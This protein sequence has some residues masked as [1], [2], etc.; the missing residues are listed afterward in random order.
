MTQVAGAHEVAGPGQ[1]GQVLDAGPAELAGEIPVGERIRR[2]RQER[3]MSQSELAAGRLSKGFI[4]QIESGRSRP[5]PESLRFIAQRL[6]VP[7]VALLPGL[8]LAQQQA[9]L[10]RAAEAAVKAREQSEA[11]T[12]LD[13]ARP[14]LSTPAELSWYHR[15]RGELL[16]L[17]DELEPA[18]DEALLAFEHV[19]GME[20]GDE[21]VRACNLVGRIHHLAGRHPAALLYLDRAAALATHPSVSPAVRA[22]VHSNRGN[23]HMRLGDPDH[24]LTAYENARAAAQDAEDLWQLAV[25]E[26][27]LGEAA[28]QRGDLPAAIGH[29]ERAVVL[30]ER[31]E[32]RQLQALILHNLGHVH[33]DQGD[34]ATARR[35]QEQAL[36]AGRAMN[37]PFVIGYAMERLA[38]IE[39]AEG[40]RSRAM[41]VANAAVDAARVL[42]ED[43]LL[44][45]AHAV[46][47]EALELNGDRAAADAAF[48]EARRIAERASNM[49]RRQVLLRHGALLRARSD[50]EGAAGCFEA[51]AHI[52]GS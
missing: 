11:G 4:S 36:N 29:A 42:G 37:D 39:V 25:A 48:A 47:G 6:G 2:L 52:S 17:R 44:A 5:S 45:I 1:A 30:F 38:A 31:I 26:M 20:P 3:G 46:L 15:L 43:A 34:L 14:L 10:L 51:A 18:L 9:F 27:G 22:L 21:T 32:M 24:A 41:L 19:S 28:R 13:E 49:E 12:L 50:F 8:E 40:D 16:I 33:A 23:T 7:M 35:L